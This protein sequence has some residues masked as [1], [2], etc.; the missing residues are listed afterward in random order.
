MQKSKKTPS[1]DLSTGWEQLL[2]VLKQAKS[3]ADLNQLL[4]FLLTGQEREQISKRVL[5]VNRLLYT[6]LSQRAIAKE[7]RLSLVTVTRCS[8]LLKNTDAK[9]KRRFS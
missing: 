8:N 3:K 2:Q 6:E 7:L 1:L 9:M 4:E 5:L